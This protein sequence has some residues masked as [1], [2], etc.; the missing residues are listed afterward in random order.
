MVAAPSVHTSQRAIVVVANLTDGLHWRYYLGSNGKQYPFRA[1]VPRLFGA[2]L[3]LTVRRWSNPEA[4]AS[5]TATHL[6]KSRD[7]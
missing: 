2:W 7:G 4:Y 3:R 6:G 1:V 5:L